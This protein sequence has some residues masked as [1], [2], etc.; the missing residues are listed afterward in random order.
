MKYAAKVFCDINH[1]ARAVFE[2]HWTDRSRNYTANTVPISNKVAEFFRENNTLMWERLI[3]PS[4]PL[5]C[6][7]EV[8]IDTH[9][10]KIGNKNENPIALSC[11]AKDYTASQ[12]DQLHIYTDASKTTDITSA[13]FFI[14]ELKVISAVLLPKP[15]FSAELIAIKLSI[16]WI[17]NSF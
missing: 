10:S 6:R 8:L 15:I 9:L 11:S 13:A 5:W 7:K 1:P 3:L 14:P 4:Q 12:S 17:L 16:E 2:P